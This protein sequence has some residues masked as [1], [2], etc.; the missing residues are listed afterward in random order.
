[1]DWQV[2]AVRAVLDARPEFAGV[3]VIPVLCFVEGTFPKWV[4]VEGNVDIAGVLV[5]GLFGTTHMVVHAG[6]F[7]LPARR[8]LIQHLDHALPGH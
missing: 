8:R 5:R 3:P 6:P 4:P 7:D 2:T 1:M